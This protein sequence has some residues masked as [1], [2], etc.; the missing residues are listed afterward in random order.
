MA[1]SELITIPPEAVV[2]LTSGDVT[3]ISV[4]HRGGA[5][6]MI[7]GSVDTTEPTS[8]EDGFPLEF[9][10]RSGSYLINRSLSEL[11]PEL[12]AVR[13]FAKAIGGQAKLIV[14]HA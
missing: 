6:V 2:Q 11:F 4:F 13:V 8:W 7:Q 12:T 9:D 10:V 1:R 5:D 3:S 14:K